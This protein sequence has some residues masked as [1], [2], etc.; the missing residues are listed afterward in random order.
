VTIPV[1]PTASAAGRLVGAAGEPLAGRTIQYGVR[2]THPDGTFG[3]QFGGTVRT[4]G[5]GT[6]VLDGL[7]PGFRY[8]MNV[9]VDVV[10]HVDGGEGDAGAGGTSAG[11]RPAAQSGSC[12]AT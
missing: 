11:P 9:A 10:R 2:V 1:G 5:D 3:D 12:S 6:F 4:D 7:V 8:E